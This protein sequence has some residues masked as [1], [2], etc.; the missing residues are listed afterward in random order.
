VEIVFAEEIAE[1]KTT[2]TEEKKHLR[3]IEGITTKPI[4]GL[5]LNEGEGS[6]RV[7]R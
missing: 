4:G 5:R 6:R 3:G 7:G 2:K 1:L